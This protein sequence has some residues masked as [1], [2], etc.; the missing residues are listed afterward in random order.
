MSDCLVGAAI[1]FSVFEQGKKV[2]EQDEMLTDLG[3]K[4]TEQG[5][6]LTDLGKK[7]TG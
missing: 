1:C 2:T 6:M 7:V 4:V 5:E 3:K